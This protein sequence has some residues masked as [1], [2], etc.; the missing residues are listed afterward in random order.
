MLSTIEIDW[1]IHRLIESERRG[2]DEPPYLAL[3]RLLNLPEP[4]SAGLATNLAS[5]GSGRPW[6]EDGVEIPHGSR[7]RMSYQHGRQQYEGVFLNGALLVNGK[8]YTSLSAAANAVAVTKDGSKTQLNG[9]NYWE[10]QF[11]GEAKWRSL[12]EMRL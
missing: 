12:R 1:D 8:S 3:R 9:W 2:F 11:P 10:V 5:I 6:V 4:A 7:A